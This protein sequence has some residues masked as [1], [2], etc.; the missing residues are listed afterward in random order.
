MVLFSK[1]R[2][3]FK[4]QLFTSSK[5]SNNWLGSL[6]YHENNEPNND[7][8]LLSIRLREVMDVPFAPSSTLRE[9]QLH[10]VDGAELGGRRG[11][12]L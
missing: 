1:K 6:S 3:L 2:E 8:R 12:G 10:T 11:G 7:N 9:R 4:L 5:D